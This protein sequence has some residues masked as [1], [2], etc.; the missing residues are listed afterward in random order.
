VNLYA[1][2]LVL[3]LLLGWP[4][5]L[6]IVV[7]AGIVLI[8]ITLGG[9]SSAI[10]NEVLQFFLIVVAVVPV[11]YIG[12]KSLGG[13]GG[14]KDAISHSSL[15]PGAT[16]SWTGLSISHTTNP[17]GA[18]WIAIVFGLGFVQS[19]G[20]WTTNFAEVQRA[21][22]ASS[23]SAARRTPLIGAFPKLLAP[24]ITIIPGMIAVVAIEGL[25]GKNP[26]LQYN[27]ALPLLM[28]E[29][30][31]N[32]MIGLALTGLLAAFMAG[33]AANVS[34]FN[35]VVTYD[36]W[37]PYVRRDRSDAYYLRFGRIATVGGILISIFTALIAS[38]YSNIMNYIQVLF[39]VFNVPLFAT[40][41]IGMFWKRMT[42]WAGFWGMVAGSV[43]ALGTYL[44]YK[45]GV[46][47]FGSDLA[48]AFWGAIIAFSLDAIVSVAVS[49]VTE[50]RPV[51]E[52]QGLVYGM[53]NDD[54]T[55][56]EADSGWYR[57]PLLLGV[58]ALGLTV[59]ASVLFI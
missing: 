38:G 37:E 50:P 8:Y 33:V 21:L 55:V 41:I 49:F 47:D 42:P 17:I 29:Y 31:P 39:S 5:L 43:G 59:V 2:A 26:D 6:G 32:G 30:F 23:L 15:G 16:H 48:E 56:T 44:L 9:L 14:L 54:D 36:L 25:G 20:Y 10:Y 4:I 3:Q 28:R 13:Y 7:A 19:F 1:L 27:N 12:L 34:A 53:A 57:S 45:G 51:A 18:N 24:A 46:L 52:L 40:F 58:A 11:T 22:S 35:T